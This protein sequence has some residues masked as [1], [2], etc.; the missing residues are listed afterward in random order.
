MEID[1]GKL[2]SVIS[3]LKREHSDNQYYEVKAANGGIPQSLKDT[4]SAF[5]N[6]PGGGVLILGV[7]EG[8][9]FEIVGVYDPKQCQQTLANYARKDFNM[10]VS[11][12]TTPLSVDG[13]EVIWA[14]IHEANKT[15][16][17]IKIKNS[18]K[19]FIRLYDGDY[20]LSELEEQLF[21]SARGPSHFDEDIIPES[22]VSD[23]DEQ[24]VSAYIA[25]RKKHSRAL[26]KMNDT[27]ILLRTGV[28]NRAGELS[29]AGAVALGIYPQ[30][31]LPNYSIKVSIHKKNGHSNSIRAINVNSIDGSLS[32]ILEE[33]LKWIENN[34][35]V[36]TMDMPNGHVRNVREYPLVVCRELI[37]NALIHRDMN[38]LSMYQNIS[39]TIEDEQLVISN[40]GGLYGLSVTEL[41]HTGSK[42]R[43]T[44]LA[45]ICQ[46]I[47]DEEGQ[48]VI[49]RLGSGIPKV[50]EELSIL[51]MEPPI[52]IDG[53]IYF[54]A[55]LK[56]AGRNET[57]KIDETILK[58]DSQS[59]IVMELQKGTRSRSELEIAT[60]LSTS[61]V[62]YALTKLIKQGKVKKIGESSSSKTKY[63]LK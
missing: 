17:P 11:I 48:N 38:P 25:N 27:E 47:V 24:L 53:G 61:Q 51:N 32:I 40:P 21:I 10:P 15:L 1:N 36:L 23:L 19:S 62:R 46:F 12:S 14:E 34:T 35:D 2:L 28:T 5:A 8:L 30:Q 55:I 59:V 45:E 42:T 33:T 54:T 7:D 58:R 16:K 60:S 52:F 56:A 4:I 43:N 6:T 63:G 26:A 39:L 22:S 29:I 50:L 20:E 13:K 9:D 18:G 49:E 44:R 37:S 3:E 41:G 57:L 31:F